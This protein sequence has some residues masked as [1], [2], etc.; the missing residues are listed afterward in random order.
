MDWSHVA[1]QFHFKR[2]FKEREGKERV[3]GRHERRGKQLL[4]D[5]KQKT[6]YWKLK[7]KNHQIALCGELYLEEAT[8]LSLDY[9]MHE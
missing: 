8:D 2:L 5:L 9:R 1:C 3:T 4:D 6:G 7:K